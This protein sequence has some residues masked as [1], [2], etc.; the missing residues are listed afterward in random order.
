MSEYVMLILALEICKKK[1]K[2]LKNHNQVGNQF[3]NKTRQPLGTN[4]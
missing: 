3:V 4:L 2:L 1:K